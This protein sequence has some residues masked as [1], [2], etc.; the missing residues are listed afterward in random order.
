MKRDLLLPYRGGLQ[1]M[2]EEDGDMQDKARNLELI[3]SLGRIP[4]KERSL[5][6]G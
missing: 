4:G 6:G 1:K 3:F 5:F 2:A